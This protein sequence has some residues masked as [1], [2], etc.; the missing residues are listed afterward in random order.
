MLRVD[1][2][3]IAPLPPLTF[4]V[5]NGECLA[6]EGPSGSGKTRLLRAIADLDRA[7]GHVFL[8]GAERNEMR[9][10]TWRRLVRY[11]A[12]DAMWWTDTARAAFVAP[13]ADGQFALEAAL[14]ALLPEL[15]LE[16]RLLDKPVSDL[17]TGERQRLAFARAII[18]A[19]RVLLLDEPT[20]GLDPETTRRVE[21]LI[22]REL[23][24]GR[25]VVLAS[26]DGAQIDRLAHVRLQL[27]RPPQP[28][29]PPLASLPTPF[30]TPNL[31]Q[32][33]YDAV[34]RADGASTLGGPAKQNVP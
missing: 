13:T 2:I 29:Q 6:V 19:P 32:A 21:A 33:R 31:E 10:P 4:S 24:A 3:R 8:D 16:P 5:A 14:H 15:L 27:A 25:S 17:S 34:L 1:K 22:Q 18:D 20:N 7:S 28:M 30:P 23:N 11:A 12:T 26:H 9:A